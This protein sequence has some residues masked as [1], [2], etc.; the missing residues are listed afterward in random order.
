MH[1]S[2]GSAKFSTKNLYKMSE[3]AFQGETI[4]N[5]SKFTQPK[6]EFKLKEML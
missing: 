6:R 5:F 1:N 4:F 3:C 2:D